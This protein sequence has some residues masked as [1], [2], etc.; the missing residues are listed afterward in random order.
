MTTTI[1]MTTTKMAT[2]TDRVPKSATPV[3]AVV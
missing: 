3:M 1:T 2:I